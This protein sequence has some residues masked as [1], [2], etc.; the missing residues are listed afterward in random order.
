MAEGRRELQEAWTAKVNMDSFHPR[1]VHEIGAHGRESFISELIDGIIDYVQSETDGDVVRRDRAN[2][3]AHVE[4]HDGETVGFAI[5]WWVFNAYWHEIRGWDQVPSDVEDD[6]EVVTVAFGWDKAAL[7]GVAEKA[8]DPI[9]LEI[10]IGETLSLEV[11]ESDL[12]SEGEP[13]IAANVMPALAKVYKIL[14]AAHLGKPEIVEHNR[15]RAAFG[16]GEGRDENPNP[17]G[18]DDWKE[19]D[20]GWE[21]ASAEQG[22]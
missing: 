6:H 9:S 7:A 10:D 2:V 8:K 16:E 22:E 3:V 11:S 13:M 20:A 14:M 15:G 4:N 12:D 17:E 21:E 1:G 5:Q 18:S 19:W